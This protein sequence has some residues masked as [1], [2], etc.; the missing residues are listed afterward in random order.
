MKMRNLFD[1]ARSEDAQSLVELALLTPLFLLL[2]FGVVDFGQAFYVANEIAGAAHAGAIYGSQNPND[3]SGIETAVRDGAP[4][5]T[6]LSVGTPTYG[7]ECA[8]GTGYSV[9]CSITPTCL[10][11]LNV[12]Y[13]VNLTVT[14]TY[15]PIVPFPGIPSSISLSS[16]A[17]MRSAGS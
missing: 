3:T 13:R 15:T 7:C 9:N 12:V 8:N 16:S 17:S 5:V 2:L 1:L 14:D 11:G 6:N 10:G 4:D